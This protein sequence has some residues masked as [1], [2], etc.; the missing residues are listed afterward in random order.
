MAVRKA[1][2]QKASKSKRAGLFFK[3]LICCIELHGIVCVTMSYWLAWHGMD[4]CESIS[5]TIVGE[6]IA[7]VVTYG[8]TKTIENVFEKNYFSFSSPT[9]NVD[10]YY[11]SSYS[12]NDNGMAG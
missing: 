8:I 2:A 11:Q 12:N 1:K 7:P 6:I 10:S 4:P 9:S 3:I 5:G